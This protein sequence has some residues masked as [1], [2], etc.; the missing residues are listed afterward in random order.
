MPEAVERPASRKAR[1]STRKADEVFMKQL[2]AII[3]TYLAINLGI[4][5]PG[6]GIGF[7]LHALLPR[8]DLGI[9]TLIGVVVTG[10]SLHFFLR[11][12]ASLR[13]FE[14]DEADEFIHGV[15]IYPD[16]PGSS[17]RKKKRKRSRDANGLNTG[18]PKNGQLLRESQDDAIWPPDDEGRS[19]KVELAGVP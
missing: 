4:L 13:L 11:L 8:V 19:S 7:L 16:L 5:L 3:A 15:T 9:G 1:A 2:L 12:F 18:G 14:G 6:I 10:L 17:R